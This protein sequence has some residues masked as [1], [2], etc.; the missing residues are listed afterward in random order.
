MNRDLKRWMLNYVIRPP[1]LLVGFALSPFSSLLRWID[2]HLAMNHQAELERD[3]HYALPFLFDENDGHQVPNE[4]APFPPSFD[5]AFV[6]IAV[7]SLLIRFCRGRGELD[8]HLSSRA[9]LSDWHELRLLLSLIEKSDNPQRSGM[10]DLWQASRLLQPQIGRLKLG[11]GENPDLELR[12]RLSEV[13]SN[14]RIAIR[15]AE[16]EINKRLM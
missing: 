13:Y 16:W 15:Q 3:I 1:L 14:D 11:L 7:G 12:Q 6:T 4:G 10:V 2:R 8:V 5:Y 9:A